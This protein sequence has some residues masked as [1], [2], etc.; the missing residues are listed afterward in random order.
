MS[1][2]ART[3][4]HLRRLGFTAGLVE[5][6]VPHR[7]IRVDLFGIGDVLGVHP[8]DRSVLLVQCTSDAHVADRLKRV[9]A[10]PELPALLAAGVA[11]EVW[12]WSL[13][14]GRWCV[15]RVALRAEVLAAV[16]I[17]APP[18]RRRARRGE[19]QRGLFDGLEPPTALDSRLAL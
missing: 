10:R 1:P 16:V 3:L 6:W 7:D 15:R 18:R 13:R 12:G 2:T 14:A 4:A 19:R 5:R 8:R 17:E 9:Q 11:V